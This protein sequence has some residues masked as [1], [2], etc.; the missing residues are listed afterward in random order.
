[1][2]EAA[3]AVAGTMAGG[4]CRQGLVGLL[5]PGFSC[6]D[7]A[8][9][10]LIEYECTHSVSEHRITLFLDLSCFYK[11]ISHSRLIEHAHAVSFPP[12]LLWG[13][14]CRRQQLGSV[15]VVFS[16]EVGSCC[17]PLR[18]VVLQH[19]RTLHRLLF[20]KNVP[21][22]YLR[23]WKLTWDKLK[24]AP[25]R[26]TLVKGPIAAMIAYL[27]DHAVD[28]SASLTWRFSEGSL[29]GPGL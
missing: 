9:R 1:M 8:V 17:D 18:T 28:A 5:G 3:L 12:L 14:L 22:K 19:W 11:T 13:A 6:L 23:L 26:W 29:S 20:S 25:K 15:D 27:Q 10:R 16:L 2:D 21:D 24:T 4:L 7:V